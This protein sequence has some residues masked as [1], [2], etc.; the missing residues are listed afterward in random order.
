MDFEK[1]RTR[2]LM[3]MLAEKETVLRIGLIGQPGAGKSSLINRLLGR[4]L[5]AVGVHTDTTTEAQQ[6]KYNDLEIVDLPGYGTGRFPLESW[7]TEFRPQELDMYIFVFDGKLHDS[8]GEMFRLLAKWQQ[9]RQHP[10]FIVRNKSD[11]IWEPSRSEEELRADIVADV[12]GKLGD[13]TAPVYFT[14]CRSGEGIDTLKQAIRTED[15]LGV[16]RSKIIANFR[17]ESA[18][19]LSEKKLLAEKAVGNYAVIAAVNGINP[20]PG[21]DISVDVGVI[22]TMLGKIRDI[23]NI[24]SEEMSKYEVLAPLLKKVTAFFSEDAVLSLIKTFASEELAKSV[25]KYVP[26]L[27]MSLAAGAGYL[28]TKKIGDRYNEDCYELM[29]SYI[30]EVISKNAKK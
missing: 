10:Y 22:K 3:E 20:L 29:S 25:G 4:E 12:R 11:D 2:I 30:E 24:D 5:F 21:V 13:S 16:K 15:R 9:E 1:E 17:A 14:S 19:E 6:E 26:F 23:Y 7:L 28:M 27:G 18:E 8:D